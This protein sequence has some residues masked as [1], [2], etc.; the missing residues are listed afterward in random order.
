MGR[1][2]ACAAAA[3]ALLAAHVAHAAIVTYDFTGTVSILTQDGGLFG[4]PGT[5]QVGDPF[6]GQFSYETG[7]TNPDQEPADT[8]HGLYEVTEIV[9]DQSVLAPF[10]P[11][12]IT[13]THQAP[14]ATVPPNPPD[15]GKDWFIATTTTQS[16]YPTVSVRL[17]GPWESAFADD[18]LPASLDA[19]DFPDKAVVG[20]VLAGIVPNPAI[21]DVGTIDTLVLAPEPAPLALGAACAAVLAIRR[22]LVQFGA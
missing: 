8:V 6:T 13:V 12:G 21:E 9:V 19:A 5:V 4:A 3:G 15:V 11:L 14:L 7:P 17:Q 22:A 20:F 1:A 2:F 10:S 16:V 18:S